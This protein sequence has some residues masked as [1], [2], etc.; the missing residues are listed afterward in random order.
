[1]FTILGHPVMRPDV[2]FIELPVELVFQDSIAPLPKHMAM[3]VA[4]YAIDEQR[5][6][7]K[8]DEEKKR[9]LKQ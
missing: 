8:N 7:K 2:G 4:N 3:R 1:M 9:W 6:K 5:K